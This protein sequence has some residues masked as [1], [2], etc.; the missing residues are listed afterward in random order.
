MPLSQQDAEKLI[1]KIQDDFHKKW[2][3]GDAKGLAAFYHADAVLIE[4]GKSAAYGLEEIEKKYVEALKTP[5]DFKLNFELTTPAADG[6]YIIHQGNFV[7]AALPD[8]P[9]P[10][11]QIYKRTSSGQYLIIHDI[12]EQP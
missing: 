7:F 12:F 3:A 1:T 5:M 10:Y 6:E 2:T 9:A 4:K 11:G 8:K